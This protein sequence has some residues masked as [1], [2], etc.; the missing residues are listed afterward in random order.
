MNLTKKMLTIIAVL[1]ASG[2]LA[3][4]MQEE[5][6]YNDN[7]DDSDY[8]QTNSHN[9]D[10][11]DADI[12]DIDTDNLVRNSAHTPNLW[13]KLPNDVVGEITRYLFALQAACP[14][15]MEEHYESACKEQARLKCV[16][17][18]FVT[19][20]AEHKYTKT[21]NGLA[22][23]W[24]R[25]HDE[26]IDD[27]YHDEI[28][29]NDALLEYP[30]NTVATFVSLFNAPILN[31]HANAN[32]RYR[33]VTTPLHIAALIGDI[34]FFK[35]VHSECIRVASQRLRSEGKTPDQNQIAVQLLKQ[36]DW[37]YNEP[38][39]Y[40]CYKIDQIG[41]RR[42]QHQ[43]AERQRLGIPEPMF[44]VLVL[45]P[46]NRYI[47]NYIKKFPGYRPYF[48]WPVLDAIRAFDPNDGSALLNLKIALESAVA[49]SDNSMIQANLS[50]VGSALVQATKEDR[51]TAVIG[52]ITCIKHNATA[53]VW[54]TVLSA[55]DRDNGWN[56][57]QWAVRDGQH[58]LVRELLA[59]GQD[60]GILASLLMSKGDDGSTVLHQ[61]IAENR[62]EIAMWLLA[63]AHEQ[64]V[65]DALLACKTNG[66][67]TFLDMEL[68]ETQELIAQCAAEQGKS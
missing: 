38:I 45:G 58:E 13:N 9:D 43:R 44:D 32:N 42:R 12:I 6:K 66:G 22:G 26:V 4:G 49:A 39:C 2:K 65:L 30:V 8:A 29:N 19:R 67:Y 34:H 52:L 37:F 10:D 46:D 5:H 64:G 20:I 40:A 41:K 7:S 51:Y 27:K 68:N 54:H 62:Y 35:A 3:Y 36:K 56:L 23:L 17:K 33:C 47:T 15:E 55:V 59:I 63:A 61:A 50:A 60:Q 16:S 1:A 53:Q 48:N 24:Q 18:N 11:N 14:A 57:L 21:C 28:I 25:F 31:L